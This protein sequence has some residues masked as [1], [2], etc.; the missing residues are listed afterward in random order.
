M[1]SDH[2]DK[3]NLQVTGRHSEIPQPHVAIDESGD[4]VTIVVT[5]VFGPKGDNL[6]GIRNIQFD[7][8]PAVTVLVRTEDGLEGEVHLSPIHGDA[9]KDVLLNIKP[10]AKLELLCPVSKEP[11]PIVGEIEDGNG[12]TYRALYL[13]EKLEEGAVVLISDV[14]GHFESRIIDEMELLSHWAGQFNE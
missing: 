1:S 9:R 8:H 3:D 13:T 4:G 11:L 5:Q 12:A 2:I 7:G 14:W 10:G 6:V